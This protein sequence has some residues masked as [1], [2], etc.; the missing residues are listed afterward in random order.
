MGLLTLEGQEG[1]VFLV[2][3]TGADAAEAVAAVADLFE[4]KFFED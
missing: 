3:A 2:S 1:T 4:K